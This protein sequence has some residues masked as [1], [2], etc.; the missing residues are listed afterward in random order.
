MELF[1]SYE[2]E[3]VG[4]VVYDVGVNFFGDWSEFFDRVWEWEE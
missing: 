1:F 3:D 4:I 2:I